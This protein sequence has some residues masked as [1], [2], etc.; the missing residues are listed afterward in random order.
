[1]LDPGP[2]QKAAG[3]DDDG[4]ARGHGRASGIGY[5]PA[6]DDLEEM[7]IDVPT[8][9]LPVRA[10]GNP[11][12]TVFP[13]RVATMQ[14]AEEEETGERVLWA[15]SAGVLYRYGLGQRYVG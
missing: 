4:C 5:A 12:R 14:V 15:T 2:G 7:P 13:D 11:F 9:E 10:R 8:G 3:D 1:M 6:A